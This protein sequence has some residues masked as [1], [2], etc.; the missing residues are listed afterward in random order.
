MAAEQWDSGEC[1]RWTLCSDC[2]VCCLCGW[3]LGGRGGLARRI[4]DPVIACD[5]RSDDGPSHYRFA[6]GNED[7]ADTAVVAGC[8]ARCFRCGIVPLKDVVYKQEDTCDNVFLCVHHD[9]IECSICK[10]TGLRDKLLRLYL[11]NVACPD[12]AVWCAGC[13]SAHPKSSS[14]AGDR[15]K[16]PNAYKRWYQWTKITRQLMEK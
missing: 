1:K 11:G 16:S 12:C 9:D 13:H 3:Q 8:G 10:R 4:K 7:L 14:C 2:D 6:C 5:V 15:S